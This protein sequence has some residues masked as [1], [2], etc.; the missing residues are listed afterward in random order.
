MFPR[1][2]LLAGGERYVPHERQAHVRPTLQ[3]TFSRSPN[4]PAFSRRSFSFLKEGFAHASFAVGNAAGER[5][6]LKA[7][8]RVLAHT[9]QSVE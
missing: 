2:V 3:A 8:R 1:L 7:P 9:L 4:P 6:V 5:R